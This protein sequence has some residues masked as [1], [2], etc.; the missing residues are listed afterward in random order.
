MNAA[1]VRRL[2]RGFAFISGQLG[3][4]LF[5]QEKKLIRKLSCFVAAIQLDNGVVP[6]K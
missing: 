1:S 6:K 4:D 3:Y 2:L 5:G